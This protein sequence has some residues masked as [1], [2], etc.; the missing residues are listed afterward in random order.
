MNPRIRTAS[1]AL[2]LALAPVGTPAAGVLL[3]VSPDT[4]TVAPGATFTMELRVPV[5]GSL[6]N[7][8]DAVVEYDPAVLTFLPRSPLALQEGP[9]MKLA[10]GNTFHYFRAAGDSLSV[11][12]SLLCANLFLSGPAHVYSLDFRAPLTPGS[13][14]VRLRRAQFYNAGTYVSPTLTADA[15]VSWGGTLGVEPALPAA[16]TL[17]VRSNPSRGTQ[18]LDLASPRA[19]VQQLV[20]YD[21]SGRLVRRLC[22]GAWPAGAR[23][24]AWDGLDEAG[25]P[26]PPGVY[27]ARFHAAD[28]TVRATLVR[29]R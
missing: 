17:A 12:H 9:D 28:R 18:W 3:A 26:A 7:G 24:V 8:Y 2:S 23:A 27:L 14:H 21:V 15:V 11:S 5:A 1:L 13:T 10:C 4:L 29:L 6:F 25:R 20:L 16:P 19:G 22:D